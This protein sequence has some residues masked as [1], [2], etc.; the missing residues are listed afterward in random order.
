MT[1]KYKRRQE[2]VKEDKVTEEQ[3]R[4]GNP[5]GKEGVMGNIRR[6]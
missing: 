1:V 6:K 3:D 4:G 2:E 5:R